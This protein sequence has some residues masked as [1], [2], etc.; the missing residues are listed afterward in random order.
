M[1]RHSTDEL[2]T[3]RAFV[4]HSAITRQI[5]HGHGIWSP[6]PKIG[7]LLQFHEDDKE[8]QLLRDGPQLEIGPPCNR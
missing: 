7:L 3:E 1:R 6:C 5:C 2:E 8:C 4:C